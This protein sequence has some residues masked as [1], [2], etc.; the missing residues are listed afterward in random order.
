MSSPAMMLPRARRVIG[1]MIVELFSFIEGVVIM[2]VC[3]AWTSK[4]MRRL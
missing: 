1:L 2:R 3:P 4:V